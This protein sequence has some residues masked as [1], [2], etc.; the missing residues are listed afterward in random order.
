[1]GRL[2]K[3]P[4]LMR[5]CGIRGCERQAHFT[6]K[7]S[8]L[9]ACGYV[10]DMHAVLLKVGGDRVQAWNDYQEAIAQG[11]FAEKVEEADI[12]AGDEAPSND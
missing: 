8:K 7:D 9:Q 11:N 4:Y 2:Y 10:C 1:M 12:P 5:K 3:T 6:I